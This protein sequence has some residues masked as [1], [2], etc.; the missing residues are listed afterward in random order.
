MDAFALDKPEERSAIKK[1]Y[2]KIGKKVHFGTLRTICHEKHSELP[3]NQRVYKGRVVFRGDIVKDADGFYAVFSEQGTSSSHMAATKFMDAS[4]RAPDCDGEDSDAIG[5]YTQVKRKDVDHLLG[6]GNV[7][8][9][10]FVSL[11]RNLWPQAW[12]DACMEDPHCLL[13]VNLYG[14]K[15]AGLLW[16][17]WSE[18]KIINKCGFERVDGW[19]C[20]YV[21]KKKQVFLPV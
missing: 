4:A 18:D 21:H 19:E 12:K 11:P 9:D 13:N 15:L 8:I 5:A 14:H 3:M 10:T 6:K 16:Q 17:K 1:R 2:E 20:L 7:M